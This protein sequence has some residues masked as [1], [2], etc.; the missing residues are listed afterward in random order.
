MVT[1]D[2]AVTGRQATAK[3]PTP[4]FEDPS[5]DDLVFKAL[6]DASRRRLLDLL[7]QRD[8]RSLG[9]LA[10]AFPAMTRFGVMKHLA[11]L[12]GAGLVTAR[13]HGREKLHY[14]NPVPIQLVY[15]RW[16]S[17]YAAPFAAALVRTKRDLEAAG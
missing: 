2:R 17:Q 3:R 12:T 11:V 9:E 8:G 16:V 1:Y 10:E 4:P 13:R 7:R 6:A 5:A 15:E 14:L